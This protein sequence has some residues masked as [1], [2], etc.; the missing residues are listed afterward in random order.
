MGRAFTGAVKGIYK[1]GLWYGRHI[2]VSLHIGNGRWEA[3]N[4]QWDNYSPRV[5][6]DRRGG[7]L[8]IAELSGIIEIIIMIPNVMRRF[9]S[10]QARGGYYGNPFL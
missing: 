10:I 6:Y 3:G 8:T 7:G 1:G 2:V 9:L 5:H 4:G